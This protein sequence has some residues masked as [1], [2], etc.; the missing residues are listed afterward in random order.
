[1]VSLKFNNVFIKDWFSIAGP[2]E[3]EGNIKNINYYLNDS[4]YGEKTHE[5]AEIKIQKTIINN[6]KQ[7]NEFDLIIGGDLSNQLGIMN[8]SL[9]ESNKSF[10]G[11]YSACASFVEGMILASSLLMNRAIS[12]ACVLTSSHMC[13]SE[14]QFRFPNEYNSLKSKSSTITATGGVGAI[15]T[16]YASRIKV[17]SATIGSIVDYG[18]KDAA[19][20]GAVMAPSAASTI[21]NHLYNMKKTIDDYDVILTG[22]LGVLGVE[23]L[24]RVLEKDHGIITDKIIDSGSILYKK[25]QK[26]YMGGSGPICLPL[27]FFNSILYSKRYKRILL[28]GTGSLHNPTLVNQKNTIPSIS[29]AIEIEVS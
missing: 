20:M 19:N 13:T 28:I 5:A 10:L 26:K 12:S 24:K 16:N 6:L 9:K 29:H 15:L 7:K 25:E 1:M 23:L 4:Y 2:D 11:I 21:Q 27:V 3:R 14:R 17:V 22:D 8:T 18:I